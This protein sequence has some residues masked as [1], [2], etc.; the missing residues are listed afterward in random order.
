MSRR[1]KVQENL[2]NLV[3]EIDDICTKY[4]VEYYLAGGT[5]LGTVRNHR[6]LPWDDDVDLYITRDNWN[7]LRN[8]IETEDNFVP[9]G[10]T[11]VLMEIQS[12]ITI[13]LLGILIIQPLQF[14]NH[15]HY[16]EKHV[17]SILNF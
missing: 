10:R 16:L 3:L 14:I 5:A 15:R 9:E 4:D 12:I 8:V 6:F 7:K 11:F 1:N 17:V 2:F 13:Q